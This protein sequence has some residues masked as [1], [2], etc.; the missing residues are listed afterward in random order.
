MTE[1]SHRNLKIAA[2][3]FSVLA[4][5]WQHIQ[6]TRL[7]YEV[8]KARRESHQ[9]AARIGAMQMDLQVSVS[10]ARL[11]ARAERLGMF[12]A[13]PE[14]LRLLEA[15]GARDTGTLLGRLISKSWRSLVSSIN[16]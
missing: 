11:A 13:S 10:P 9:L 14:S 16:T 15:P 12:P 8:E 4:L 1:N 3:G 6:A 2:I 5:V 7:G